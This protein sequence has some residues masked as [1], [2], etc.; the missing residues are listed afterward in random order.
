MLASIDQHQ[1]QRTLLIITAIGV[2][3]RLQWVVVSLHTNINA[4]AAW[5]TLVIFA[6]GAYWYFEDSKREQDRIRET[7]ND[8]SRPRRNAMLAGC[9]TTRKTRTALRPLIREHWQQRED[10][11]E[12]LERGQL[13]LLESLAKTREAIARHQGHHDV[14]VILEG[15]CHSDRL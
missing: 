13:G 10:R 8:H 2:L 4:L 3:T 9:W 5:A 6:C 15:K 12:E 7:I 11:F 1:Q 14:S